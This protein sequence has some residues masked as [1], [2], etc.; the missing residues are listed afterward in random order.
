MV[1]FANGVL[2]RLTI[3]TGL[4]QVTA[5]LQDLKMGATPVCPRS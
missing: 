3:D 1:V 2:D 5:D 4:L